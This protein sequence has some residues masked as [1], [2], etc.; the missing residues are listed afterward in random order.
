MLRSVWDI[1]LELSPWLLL[2]AI[3]AGLLHVLVPAGWLMRHLRG[4]AGVLKA[5]LVGVPLPLCS[6]GVIPVGLGL[7]RD[8]ASTGASVGF[9]ISTPQTG[10]DSILVSASFL[11]LPFALFKVVAAMV[12]GLLGGWLADH[13]STTTDALPPTEAASSTQS[14]SFRAVIDQGLMLIRAIWVWLV[15][16]VFASALITWWLPENSLSDLPAADGIS[17]MLITLVISIPLYVCATASVPIAA[18]L[19]ASGLP[20]GA[21]LVFLMAGPATNIATLGAVYR[22]L[23]WRAM[24][25]YLGAIIVG[26]VTAGLAFDWL[27]DANAIASAMHHH[28]SHWWSIA[29]AVVVCVLFVTF[30]IDDARHWLRRAAPADGPSVTLPVEGMTC[31]GC[32]SRL[33]RVLSTTSGVQHA[34]VSFAAGEAVIQSDRSKAALRDVIETAGFRV[35]NL[36]SVAD[37]K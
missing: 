29:S 8:G 33:E 28:E 25:V 36:G 11:G 22:A 17:A 1:L 15:V 20:P 23:G 32:A 4:R 14:R 24:S 13:T 3:A 37:L 12:T 31:N 30:A 2:G 7:R 18:A 5:V 27:I 26:S 9:L 34:S 21:A 6:C 35:P 19:V 10:V 16:G